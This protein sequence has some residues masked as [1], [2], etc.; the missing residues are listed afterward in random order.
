MIVK[1][2]NEKPKI[3]GLYWLKEFSIVYYGSE[4]KVQFKE[5]TIVSVEDWGSVSSGLEVMALGNECGKGQVDIF[6]KK[7]LWYGPIKPPEGWGKEE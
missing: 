5:P 3:P 4:K 6:D 1:W 2:T 7:C